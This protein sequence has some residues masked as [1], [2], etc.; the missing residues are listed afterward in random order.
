MLV[1]LGKGEDQV[2]QSHH[3]PRWRVL[4]EGRVQ[5]VGFRYTVSTIAKAFPVRGYVRN[6]PDGRVEVI[7]EGSHSDVEGFLGEIRAARA[8]GIKRETQSEAPG[9]GEFTDFTVRM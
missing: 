8:V 2:N 6:L 4:Y 7:V 9:T 5:G 1:S 3:D